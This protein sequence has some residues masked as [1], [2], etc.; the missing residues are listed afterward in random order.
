MLLPG[1]PVQGLRGAPEMLLRRMLL[2]AASTVLRHAATEQKIDPAL[3]RIQDA[4]Q[5]QP[6]YIG[7]RYIRPALS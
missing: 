6:E 2:S 1:A 5:R 4:L 7:S 3:D